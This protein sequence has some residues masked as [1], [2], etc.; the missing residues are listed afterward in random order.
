MSLLTAPRTEVELS[1]EEHACRAIAWACRA[2]VALPFVVC[3][4][5]LIVAWRGLA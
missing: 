2:L 5:A 3:A 1:D 4:A